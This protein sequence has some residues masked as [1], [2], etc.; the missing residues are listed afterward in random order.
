[1]SSEA[2]GGALSGI[3]VV[4][5][6]QLAAGPL[7]TSLL[8]D[9]GADV[10]KIERP[11]L[12]DPTR[13]VDD[14]F[15]SGMGSTFVSLNRNK[16]S[17]ALDF[18]KEAHRGMISRMLS[19]ADVAVENLKPGVLER[20][21]FSY[22]TASADNPRLIW[23]SINGYG[24]AGPDSEHAAVDTVVQARGGLIA[25]NGADESGPVRLPTPIADFTAALLG[26]YGISLALYEREQSGVGQKVE[27]SLLRGVITHFA[28]FIASQ[29]VT[30]EPKGFSGT[31]GPRAQ[32]GGLYRARDGHIAL[33]APTH[34]TWRDLLRV[35]ELTELESDPRFLT[36]ELRVANR[37]TL[38]DIMCGRLADQGV[39][40]W[41]AAFNALGVPC[42]GVNPFAAVLTDPQVVA[43]EMIGSVHVD[44][45]GDVGVINHPVKFGRTPG[46]IRSGPPKLGQHTQDVLDEMEWRS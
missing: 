28:N 23:C 30:G 31:L 11:G 12:G 13:V 24:S 45:V 15:G 41:V 27:V 35:L 4:D 42:S 33:S 26:L 40:E 22:E 46:T 3:T 9:L 2:G 16:R 37:T 8:G 32:P 44:Q 25:H 38:S 39:T 19:K 1:M 18:G 43:N 6:T 7:C 10:I 5:F 14:V 29:P 21:G 34:R 20:M 36:N 17:I